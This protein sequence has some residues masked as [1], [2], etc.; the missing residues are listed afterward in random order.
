MDFFMTCECKTFKFK[1]LHTVLY[2]IP[3]QNYTCPLLKRYFEGNEI[4]CGG[5]HGKMGN[6]HKKQNRNLYNAKSRGCI[7]V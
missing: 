5:F 2:S 3:V 4:V 7:K 6:S 1:T